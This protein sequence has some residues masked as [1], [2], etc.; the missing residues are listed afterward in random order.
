MERRAAQP[1]V[2]RLAALTCLCDRHVRHTALHRGFSVPGTV[3][4]GADT[5]S[6]QLSPPF[7]HASSSH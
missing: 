2:Q 1:A 3:L 7:I 5:S 4:P 6:R